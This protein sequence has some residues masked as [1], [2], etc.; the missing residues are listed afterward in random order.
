MLLRPMNL[1]V[2]ILIPFILTMKPIP[3]LQ[4]GLQNSVVVSEN[5]L[6]LISNS[7]V[8]QFTIL[9]M[10]RDLFINNVLF[11]QLY[12]TFVSYWGE[13]PKGWIPNYIWH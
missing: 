11:I 7:R 12:I 5:Y 4:V 8:E 6:F 1:M 2:Q 9:P 10:I 3:S 13:L